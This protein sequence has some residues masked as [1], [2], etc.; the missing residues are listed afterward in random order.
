MASDVDICNLALGHLGDEA[1]VVSINPP[2]QSAQANYCSR[3]YPSSLSTV[4]DDHAWGFATKTVTLALLANGNSLWE[5]CYEAPSDIINMLAV[6]DY[7]AVGDIN[8]GTIE[9]QQEFSMELDAKGNQ[10]IYT[11]QPNAMLKYVSYVT[12]TAQFPP[13]FVDALAWMLAANLA[14]IIVKGDVGVSASMKC[15]EA[16]KMALEKA[17]ES[18]AQN[19]KITIRPTPAGIAARG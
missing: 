15:M 10:V 13:K 16:Y 4:L 12:N 11:N 6:F 7:S 14:G 2:D 3:F 19:R 5:Y 18:D 8:H 17:I 9:N 1:N